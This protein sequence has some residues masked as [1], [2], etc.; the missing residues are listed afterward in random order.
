[1]LSIVLAC[2]HVLAAEV[3]LVPANMPRISTIDER[4]QSY[5]I[6]MVEVTGG[7]FWKPYAAQTTGPDPDLYSQRKPKDLRNARLRRFATALSPAYVRISGTSANTT[8]FAASDR[9]PG[10]PPAGFKTVLTRRQWQGVIDFSR[11]VNAPIVTSFAVGAGARDA[12]GV[13]TAEQARGLLAATRSMGGHIVA[14]E[15]M[16][17]P[18]LPASGGAPDGYGA[19]A[20]GR[21]FAA[22]RAFMKQEAPGVTILG[23]GTVGSP[24]DASDLFAASAQGID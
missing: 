22:F 18:D 10:T 16:N 21:D 13:W 8:Y 2:S 12:E 24:S 17:E 4:F 1:M 20:Y 3:S 11:A 23:P 6:E 14:A 7:P 15:L 9:A 19:A 5:N